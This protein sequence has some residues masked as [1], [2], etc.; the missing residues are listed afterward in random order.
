MRAGGNLGRF[1][2]L[3]CSLLLLLLLYPWLEGGWRGRLVVAILG[4]LIPLA[5]VYAVGR[6]RR[7]L[8][9]AVALALP[10]VGSTLATLPREPGTLGQGPLFLLPAAF[11]L[12]AVTVIAAYVLG[13]R[14][15]TADTL[16]GAACVYLLLGLTWTL[17]Y[18]VLEAL[19]PGAIAVA[20]PTAPGAGDPPRLGDLLYFSFVTLTTLG[21]GDVAPVTSQARSLAILEATTGVLYLAILIARLVGMYGSG[22]REGE[23]G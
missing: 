16:A 2:L 19:A 9:A 17:L 21:Y 1:S 14:E 4:I 11:Y 15:V 18:A 7:L 5:G 23:A 6:G 10:A 3:L 8:V 22:A 13:R 12:F 20:S